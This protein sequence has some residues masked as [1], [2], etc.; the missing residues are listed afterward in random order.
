VVTVSIALPLVAN[1][2]KEA[3]FTEQLAS[4]I[5]IGTA[6]LKLTV[7][8]NPVAGLTVI[9]DIPAWPGD[10]MVMLAGFADRVKSGPIPSRR[11]GIAPMVSVELW[12]CDV[13]ATS[14]QS[15]E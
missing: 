7:P 15:A 11:I 14:S 12:E 6:Q 1:D 9:V 8:L 3:G 13:P 5:V 10:G 2:A 4:V